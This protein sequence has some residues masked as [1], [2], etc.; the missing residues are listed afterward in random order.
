[1]KNFHLGKLV[2][3]LLLVVTMSACIEEPTDSTT[4][5]VVFKNLKVELFQTGGAN[6][7]VLDDESTWQ[8]VYKESA[9]IAIENKA[10]GQQYSLDYNPNDF[11]NPYQITLQLKMNRYPFGH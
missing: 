9:T 11:T 8:N 1:M 7:R 3:I 2:P 4:G 5:N 6:E 10:D